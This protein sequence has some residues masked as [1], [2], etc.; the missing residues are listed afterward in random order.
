MYKRQL[1]S[2]AKCS[3]R[4][5]IL[6]CISILGAPFTSEVLSL[7]MCIRDSCNPYIRLEAGSL[8]PHIQAHNTSHKFSCRLPSRLIS[9]KAEPDGSNL[10]M[11]PKKMCI[12]DSLSYICCTALLPD[13][14]LQAENFPLK[15]SYAH[16]AL[17]PFPAPVSY[18]HLDVYKRQSRTIPTN[19]YC[20]KLFPL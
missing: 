6:C 5:L 16:P 9:I 12:R 11:F 1:I 18:T 19:T 2:S 20:V 7:E 15:T 3:F 13:D 10:R 4:K 8:L 17:M 14:W